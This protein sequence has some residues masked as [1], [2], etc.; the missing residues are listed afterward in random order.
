M[1]DDQGSYAEL[2]EDWANDPWFRFPRAFIRD[3]Q[4]SWEARAIAAWMAS[5]DASFRFS[6][7]YIVRSG[8]AG[9][10][11]VRKIM[12]DLEAAGYLER[13]RI[14]NEDGSYGVLVYR[15]HPRPHR[16]GQESPS[17]GPA[18]EN[19][20]VAAAAPPSENRR[21]EPAPDL[22]APA[23]PAPDFQEGYKE[24][25][26]RKEGEKEPA[27]ANRASVEALQLIASLAFGRHVRPTAREAGELALLVDAAVAG[28][29]PLREV[30]RHAQAKVNQ[31]KTHPISYLRRGLATDNLPV[32]AV[33]AVPV[34]APVAI[35][36]SSDAHRAAVR[37][38]FGISR[39]ARYEQLASHHVAD[40]QERT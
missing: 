23:E 29:L 37:A 35:A 4:L 20:G 13:V 40:R 18:P 24:I 19:Q 9:R 12:N 22:P 10:D 26:R 36:T 32:P 21:S 8:S 16:A 11:K 33:P 31:A 17:S 6:V 15:L 1:N 5:H 34:T 38:S 7:D 28:G 27:T 30:K 14:R 2:S 3:R 39:G 25:K